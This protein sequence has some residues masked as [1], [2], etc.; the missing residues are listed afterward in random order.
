F[1]HG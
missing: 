1:L